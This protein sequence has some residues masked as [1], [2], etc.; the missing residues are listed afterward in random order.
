MGIFALVQV[1]GK[2]G[3]NHHSLCENVFLPIPD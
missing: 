3:P 1:F 2:G